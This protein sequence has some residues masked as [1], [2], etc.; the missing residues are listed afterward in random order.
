[1]LP[2]LC[3]FLL[4]IATPCEANKD[5]KPPLPT[6]KSSQADQNF[7]VENRQDL[8]SSH[9]YSEQRFVPDGTSQT[10]CSCPP[11]GAWV[12][13]FIPALEWR[14]GSGRSYKRG[15]ETIRSFLATY[16]MGT[17][18][19]P[20]IDLRAHRVEKGRLATN[21]GIGFRSFS[22]C[23]D[24]MYGLNLYYDFR[25][26]GSTSLQQIGLGAEFFFRCWELRCNGYIPI[27][28]KQA[29]RDVTVFTYP[30]DFSAKRNRYE[31]A[32]WGMD[33]ELGRAFSLS[34]F[35]F[36]TAIGPYTYNDGFQ[37]ILGGMWRIGV[38]CC[39]CLAASLYVTNDGYFGTKVQ[40][41]L[42]LYAPLP[43][44]LN[45]IRC[46]FPQVWRNEIILTGRS[47]TFKNNF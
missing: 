23:F 9:W 8:P 31:R 18:C 44:C 4:V 3:S 2:Y 34:C 24:E 36:F 28:R 43:S 46:L 30:G 6:V 38:E 1:M 7:L 14:I 39:H 19:Y 42:T 47:C 29:L 35:D 10:C 21:V 20:F 16:Q 32:Q 41:E 37:G 25:R 45:C 27:G 22:P 15:Y 12:T 17:R 5:P 40:G 13:T 33:L 11:C 26:L